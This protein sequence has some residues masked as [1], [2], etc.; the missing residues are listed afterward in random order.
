MTRPENRLG[1]VHHQEKGTEMTKENYVAPTAIELGNFD[2]ETGFIGHLE[3]ESL[4]QS[5][6][7][8]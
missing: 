8:W 7:S 6:F 4:L 2:E 3:Y 5:W 1:K